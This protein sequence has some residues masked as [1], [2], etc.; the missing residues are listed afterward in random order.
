MRNV[1]HE[2]LTARHAPTATDSSSGDV[3]SRTMTLEIL[4]LRGVDPNKD[5]I[6]LHFDNVPPEALAETTNIFASVDVAKEP[7]PVLP[8]E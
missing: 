8:P 3:V 1:E 5:R 4:E 7:A 6:D 2:P